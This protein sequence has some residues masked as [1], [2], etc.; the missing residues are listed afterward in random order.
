ML[1]I[2]KFY[3]SLHMTTKWPCRLIFF[4]FFFETRLKLPLP[5]LMKQRPELDP[6]FMLSTIQTL[7]EIVDHKPD[8]SPN[9]HSGPVDSNQNLVQLYSHTNNIW[10]GVKQLV[11]IYPSTKS[12][13]QIKLPNNRYHSLISK[14][15]R[16]QWCK[17]KDI[18]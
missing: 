12:K 3:L 6:Y 9:L 14:F 8:S 16:F 4:F 5:V 18:T 2:E 11:T 17:T 1:C 7:A 15:K 13:Q 10:L